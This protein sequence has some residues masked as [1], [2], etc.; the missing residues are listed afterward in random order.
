MNEEF[1][2]IAKLGSSHGL[3]GYIR[4]IPYIEPAELILEISTIFLENQNNYIEIETESMK[5]YKK[6]NW[7][8]K[9]KQ[10]QSINDVESLTNLYLV[11]RED[12][13]PKLPENLYYSSDIIGCNVIDMGGNC[14]GKVIDIFKYSNNDIYEI[15]DDKDT[16]LL[17]AVKE[18]IKNIDLDCRVIKV[19]LPPGI[20]DI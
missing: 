7:L 19:Q 1:V 5:P 8:Y 14:L 18:F 9:A 3:K 6:N 12:D 20:K 2:K 17:P 4:L 10:W 13:L 15:G 16:F 11:C